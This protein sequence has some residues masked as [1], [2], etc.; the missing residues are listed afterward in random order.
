[1]RCR[2]SR[3]EEGEEEE[4][5]PRQSGD[6]QTEGN[7]LTKTKG[8]RVLQVALALGVECIQSSGVAHE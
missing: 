4:D 3:K 6:R 1:L 2:F 7:T 8:G 5:L